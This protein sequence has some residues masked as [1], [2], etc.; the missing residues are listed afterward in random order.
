MTITL[1]SGGRITLPKSVRE[2]LGLKPGDEFLVSLEE[3]RIVLLPRPR[4]RARNLP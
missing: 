4:C 3:V 2:A 1:T